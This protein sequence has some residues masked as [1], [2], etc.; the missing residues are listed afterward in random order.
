[1]IISKITRLLHIKN[2][3]ISLKRKKKRSKEIKMA[4][5][6]SKKKIF[7]GKIRKT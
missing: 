2:N 5:I 7:N 3:V 6:I 4:N 1:M